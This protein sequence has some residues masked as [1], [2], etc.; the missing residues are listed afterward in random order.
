[1]LRAPRVG[2][3]NTAT[4]TAR[5]FSAPS[6]ST[7]IDVGRVVEPYLAVAVA[8]RIFLDLLVSNALNDPSLG[9]V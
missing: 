8:G 5:T 2:S 3:Q 9:S 1:V 7:S 6:S 4:A